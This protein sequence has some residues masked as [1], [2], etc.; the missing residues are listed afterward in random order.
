M[1]QG[2]PSTT[3]LARRVSP[4]PKKKG[5][6]RR[7]PLL[8]SIAVAVPLLTM[9][10]VCGEPLKPQIPESGK[11]RPDAGLVS[12]GEE[13]T[14]RIRQIRMLIKSIKTQADAGAWN[15]SRTTPE[16]D[17]NSWEQRLR[18]KTIPELRSI[19]RE[20][21]MVMQAGTANEYLRSGKQ[22]D[23]EESGS[24]AQQAKRRRD[25]AGREIRRRKEAGE[26][27]PVEERRNTNP[28][29]EWLGGLRGK[30]LGE[31][32]ALLKEEMR[33]VKDAMEYH[34]D[35]V[36]KGDEEGAAEASTD[37]AEA[38]KHLRAIRDEGN[39]KA[40]AA[41]SQSPRD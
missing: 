36:R 5:W 32:E 39:A 19:W 10:R 9:L 35:S 15:A 24:R 33:A 17:L 6:V 23:W 3:P 21:N 11:G 27:I 14:A 25:A 12:N 16:E 37:F 29:P 8:S 20:Q 28:E 1:K 40:R 7:H 13:R 22:V 34:L 18:E 4:A 31:L 26:E 41:S 2:N 30:S 38:G